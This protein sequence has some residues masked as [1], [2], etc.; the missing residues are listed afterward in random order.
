MIHCGSTPSRLAQRVV[1]EIVATGDDTTDEGGTLVPAL[2]GGGLL[3][4]LAGGAQGFDGHAHGLTRN[5]KGGPEGPPAPMSSALRQAR[6]GTAARSR[7]ARIAPT[8]T[9]AQISA[10]SHHMYQIRPIA[11][12]TAIT[13]RI[14]PA[15]VFRGMWMSR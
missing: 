15:P 8:T 10:A 5:K 14:T 9:A 1:D 4:A 13:D 2:V 3:T 6:T 12:A 11:Q 7:L